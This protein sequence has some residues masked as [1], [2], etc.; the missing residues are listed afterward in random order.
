MHQILSSAAAH[1]L[2]LLVPLPETLAAPSHADAAIR[3]ALHVLSQPVNDVRVL[4][5]A[6]VRERFERAEAGAPPENLVAFR[7]KGDSTT[8]INASS[9][10]YRAA[11]HQPSS[12]HVLRLAATLVHEQAHD[13]AGEDVAYRRQADFVRSRLHALPRNERARAHAYWRTLEV[14]AISMARAKAA[15]R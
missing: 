4:S 5:P 13:T 7:L 10:V 15:R 14:R 1:V 2:L 9:E 11:A 12:F 3:R 6:E 8:Y